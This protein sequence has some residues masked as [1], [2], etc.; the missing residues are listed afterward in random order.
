MS[1][2]LHARIFL[3]EPCARL[4]QA[5]SAV[6]FA[7]FLIC[8]KFKHILY[9]Y[10]IDYV[11]NFHDQLFYCGRY[12]YSL[13]HVLKAF[14]GICIHPKLFLKER[15]LGPVRWLPGESPGHEHPVT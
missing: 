14:Q 9:N 5:A 4:V 8:E 11:V 3:A 10:R 7:Y 13:S 2:T 6:G 1:P 15:I 12:T